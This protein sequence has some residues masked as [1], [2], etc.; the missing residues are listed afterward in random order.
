[1]KNIIYI[2]ILDTMAEWE[3][4][5]ITQAISMQEMLKNKKK[6]IVKTVAKTNKTITT[7]GGLKITPD[8]T[9]EEIDEQNIASLILPGA[10]SFDN[11]EEILKKVS[12][13]INK[14]ILIAGICGST[15][16]LCN[17]GIFD[18]YKHTSNS[19]DYLKYFSKEYTGTNLYLDSNAVVDN[20]LITANSA[21]S[22]LFT[23]YILKY[24]NVYPKKTIEYWYKYFSTGDSKY[25]S[26]MIS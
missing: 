10:Q 24:L 1:M 8:C 6:F 15:L 19:L 5:Y 20:N 16:A 12:I 18:K 17:L 3:I 21:S 23:K 22:L 11:E 13:Y 2:Y 7:L 25:Y 4:T 14:D 9:I 26:K